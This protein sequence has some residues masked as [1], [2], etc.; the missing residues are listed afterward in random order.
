MPRVCT[1]CIHP[2]R[3]T[4]D[5]SLEAGQSLRTVSGQYGLSKSSIDRHKASHLPAALAQNGADLEREF[6]V[7]REA[8]HRQYNALR[9][10][11]RAVMRAFEG[12][13]QIRSEEEWQA[14]CEDARKRY[15]SGRF[16]I[17]RLG[18]ERF[19]DPQLMATLWQLRQ[20][21]LEEYGTESPAMT[22]VIDLAV[23]TYANVLRIQGWIGDLALVIEQE[24]FAEDSLKVKLRQQHGVQFDGFAV[25][26]ALR[27]LREQLLPVCERV[28]RQLLQNLQAL[29][30]PQRGPM[31]TVAI[32]QARNVNVAQQ[33][34]NIHR[35]NGRASPPV[36]PRCMVDGSRP[37]PPLACQR[38]R[39]GHRSPMKQIDV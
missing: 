22:M 33:Q 37:G 39:R 12:W 1:I 30:R 8:D 29:Q 20:G 19:L 28:N 14:V 6:Q 3:A 31:P 17:E 16:L 7:A 23:T 35:S 34:V 4:I 36:D 26:E 38:S 13:G 27:R 5:N 18:A 32:G 24:L 11:A 9:K 25:E 15:Q 21:L 10:H 2:A